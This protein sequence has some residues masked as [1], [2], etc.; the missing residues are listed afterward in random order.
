MVERGYKINI[1]IN[2]GNDKDGRL[3]SFRNF[4]TTP[5]IPENFRK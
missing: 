1:E 2:I 5:K 3:W 4:K